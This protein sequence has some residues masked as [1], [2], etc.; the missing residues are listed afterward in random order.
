MAPG[1]EVNPPSMRTGSA[2]NAMS[3][4]ENCTPILVPH[5]M[6]ATSATKPASDHTMT[7]M[8]LSE[9]PTESAA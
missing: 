4:S 1:I 3:E 7:Q 9:I 6:P 2:F 8:K 5:M